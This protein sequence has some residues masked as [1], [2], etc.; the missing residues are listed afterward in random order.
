MLIK[1]WSDI[2]DWTVEDLPFVPCIG[3]EIKYDF[4]TYIVERVV[5]DCNSYANE[6][7]VYLD[8]K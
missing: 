5:Y 1:F 8:V 6:I 4:R 3:M 7:H 2:D